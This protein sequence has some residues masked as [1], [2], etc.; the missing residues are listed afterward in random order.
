MLVAP[1]SYTK[2]YSNGDGSSKSACTSD[3]RK[4]FSFELVDENSQEI[5]VTAFNGASDKF[6]SKI[7]VIHV[8]I[9]MLITWN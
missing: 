1:R 5:R 8:V 4:M 2:R 7:K 3:D 6:S 9:I